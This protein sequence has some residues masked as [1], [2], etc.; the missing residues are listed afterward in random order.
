MLSAVEKKQQLLR[1]KLQ[2]LDTVE[3]D[4]NC[5][6]KEALLEPDNDPFA[7]APA[8]EDLASLSSSSPAPSPLNT[9]ETTDSLDV[10]LS[11]PDLFHVTSDSVEFDNFIFSVTAA[12]NEQERPQVLLENFE[13]YPSQAAGNNYYACTG[14]IMLNIFSSE[15][16]TVSPLYD[17]R[18][19][20]SS[21]VREGIDWSTGLSGHMGLTSASA[22]RKPKR[23]EIRMMG[24]HRGIANIRRIRPAAAGSAPTVGNHPSW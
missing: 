21:S 8:F 14:N 4:L 5:K 15:A 24:E 10:N 18:R 17:V 12:R 9:R 22:H 19:P 2:D 11:D 3:S 1:G 16:T 7:H 20:R 23:R 13:S 6:L